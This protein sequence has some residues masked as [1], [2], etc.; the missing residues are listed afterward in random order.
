MDIH[1]RAYG[2]EEAYEEA[3]EWTTSWLSFSWATDFYYVSSGVPSRKDRGAYL[4]KNVV[5]VDGSYHFIKSYQLPSEWTVSL[6][7]YKNQN[8]PRPRTPSTNVANGA[9]TT[10]LEIRETPRSRDAAFSMASPRWRRLDGVASRWRRVSMASRVD[11]VASRWRRETPRSRDGLLYKLVDFHAGHR[12]RS[13]A[14]RL[15]RPLAPGRTA[16]G[17]APSPR[18]YRRYWRPVIWKDCGRSRNESPKQ[19]GGT[20]RGLRLPILWPW[21]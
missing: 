4:L 18:A 8:T 14:S 19:G 15:S 7:A 5:P 12:G 21:L 16:H 11:G 9:N 6:P 1:R 10:S 13:R 3:D 2:M 17:E 20:W